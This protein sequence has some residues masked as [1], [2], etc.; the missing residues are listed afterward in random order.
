[1]K[2][3]SLF[4]SITLIITQFSFGQEQTFYTRDFYVKKENG[5]KLDYLTNVTS[6][7]D[8][9]TL[10]GYKTGDNT[11]LHQ[12]KVKLERGQ[13]LAVSNWSSFWNP[14]HWNPMPITITTVPFKMRPE[15]NEFSTKAS[16]GLTNVGLNFDLL[17]WKIDRYFPDAN[18]STH[19]FYAGIW[20][21]PSVEEL[22]SVQTRGFLSKDIKSKQLF[23]STAL[24]LN[25]SYNNLTFTFVPIG[26]DLA[27]SSIGK[28]WIYDNRRWWG[29]GV[30]IEPKMFSTIANK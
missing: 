13:V 18:K 9:L 17:K 14:W 27:T 20:I 11:T 10:Y 3:L 16:S 5:V 2:N 24:T 22:D 29:F 1:M 8:T 25:Y 26:F 28:E 23:V 6:L 12:R 21:A 4:L 30:G 15:I 7:L 19:K